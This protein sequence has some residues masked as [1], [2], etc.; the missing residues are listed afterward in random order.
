[1]LSDALRS[2]GPTITGDEVEML[3]SGVLSLS[4]ARS[5]AA[6][7]KQLQGSLRVELILAGEQ[8]LPRAPEDRDVPYFVTQSIR[9]QLA[10]TLPPERENVRPA[11]KH[12]VSQAKRV[13]VD[14]CDISVEMATVMVAEETG[15]N[16]RRLPD[17][18]L[19]EVVRDLPR[20]VQRVAV[21]A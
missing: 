5:F 20:L 21:K 10:K 19:V 4:H 12:L 17:W 6:F 7:I 14:L 11:H 3:A 18:F 1:M 15:D 2:Y 13:L 9:A 8:P 16:P